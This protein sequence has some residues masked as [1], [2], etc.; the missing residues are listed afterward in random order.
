MVSFSEMTIP[1]SYSSLIYS[2][3]QVYYTDFEY[4]QHVETRETTI[5]LAFCNFGNVIGLYLGMSIISIS[6]VIYY[7]PYYY[8]AVYKARREVG[9]NGLAKDMERISVK[10][11]VVVKPMTN[12]VGV[13]ETKV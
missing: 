6:H 9:P 12:R 11:T 4:R 13:T 2:R 1:S 7:V 5:Y 8:R 10:K 3:V